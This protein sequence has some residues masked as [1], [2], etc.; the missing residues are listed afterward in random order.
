MALLEA[1]GVVYQRAPHSASVAVERGHLLGAALAVF[2]T[3]DV[4]MGL[5]LGSSLVEAPISPAT[6]ALIGAPWAA[7]GACLV[8]RSVCVWRPDS[9]SVR[10]N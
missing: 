2:V 7:V 5:S 6:V 10:V 8:L 1:E 9:T 3:V 4:G